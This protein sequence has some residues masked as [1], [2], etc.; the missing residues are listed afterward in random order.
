MITRFQYR[1]AQGRMIEYYYRAGLLL[2]ESDWIYP[3]AVDFSTRNADPYEVQI[4]TLINTQQI[5]VE[6]ITNF[7]GQTFDK[8]IHPCLVK[9][10]RSLLAHI[11]F[12]EGINISIQT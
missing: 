6:I 4:L 10:V 5:G 7:P 9:L 8:Y 3:E 2:T 12:R 11:P 1:M